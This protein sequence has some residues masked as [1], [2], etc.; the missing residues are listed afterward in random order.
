MEVAVSLWHVFAAAWGKTPHALHLLPC[1]VPPMGD[2]DL[3]TSPMWVLPTGYSSWYIAPPWASSMKCNPSG[4]SILQQ[5]LLLPCVYRF[6]Q[7]LP[8]VCLSVGSQPLSSACIC[9]GVGPS[10]G[11]RWIFAP[12]FT[13]MGCRKRAAGE[14][15][16]WCLKHH[17]FLLP[18]WPLC[19]QS[20]FSH[21][22]SHILLAAI[23]V[24][25]VGFFCPS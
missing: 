18:N 10:T 21:V 23:A 14:F 1:G 24:E 15:L 12:P 11:C 8:S 9:F 25:Q 6:Y 16:F 17:L 19:L 22:L 7:E 4:A 3:Q 5:R 2:S 20:H 13:S